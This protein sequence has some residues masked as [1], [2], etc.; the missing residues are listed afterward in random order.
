MKPLARLALIICCCALVAARATTEVSDKPL[1]PPPPDK[2]QII[3]MQPFKPLDGRHSVGLFEVRDST[4]DLLAVLV[5]KTEMVELVEPGQHLF[6]SF[7]SDPNYFKH[8]QVS[9]MRANVDPGKRYYVV[10][11]FTPYV[12]Y[13]LRPVHKHGSSDFN[14]GNPKFQDW[15][16]VCV[17]S[18]TT[19]EGFTSITSQQATLETIQAS[20]WEKWQQKTA[21]AQAELTLNPDDDIAD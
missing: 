11:R 3:F 13:E 8:P 16:R 12:G 1:S 4:T 17:L 10:S 5:S 7:I 19:P 21:D 14:A 2:A 18:T 9:F 20:S 6:M 15:R